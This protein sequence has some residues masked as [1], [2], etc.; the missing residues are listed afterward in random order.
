MSPY[1]DIK[2]AG[3]DAATAAR[4]AA[5]RCGRPASSG[6]P[7]PAAPATEKGP[8]APTARKLAAGS[9]REAATVTATLPMS[10]G[11]GQG[12]TT[13]ANIGHERTSDAQADS[14]HLVRRHRRRRPP[15]TTPRSSRTRASATSTRY[16]PDMPPPMTEGDVLTV[17]FTLDGQ[18]YVGLNGGP[19]FPFTEAISFQIMCRTRRRPTTTGTGSPRRRGEQ[20]RLAQGQ[21]RRLLAGRPHRDDVAAP[22]SRPRPGPAGDPGDARHAPDRPRRDQAGR[23]QRP[24]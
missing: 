18:E 6:T 11:A 24:A 8:P 10:S 16:G 13:T 23:R 9:C 2:P 21:V 17:S 3:D 22:G 1:A 12:L 14:V 15:R 4:R 5:C 19:Q 7:A 20:V